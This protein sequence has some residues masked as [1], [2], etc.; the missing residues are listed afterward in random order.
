MRKLLLAFFIIH[1]WTIHIYAAPVDHSR[2]FHEKDN[3]WQLFRSHFKYHI[4]LIAIKKY[5]DNSVNIILSEPPNRVKQADIESIIQPFRASLEIK[6]WP[7]GVDGFVKDVVI[8][9]NALTPFQLNNLLAELHEIIF[10]TSYKAVFLNLDSL[11]AITPLHNLNYQ[12]TASELN[13]W[14]ITDN[15]PFVF[16]DNNNARLTI[17]QIIASRL[18]GEYFSY[19]KAFVLWVMPSGQNISSQ[20]KVIRQFSLDADL[21]IGA[22]YG[23]NTLVVIGRKRKESVYALPPLRTESVLMLAAANK[24]ELAQSYERNSLFAGKMTNLKDWAPIYLSK[25]LINTE[26]GSLLNITDQMLKS[27][28]QMNRIQYDNFPYPYPGGWPYNRTMFDEIGSSSLTY[29]WNTRGVGYAVKTG[30]LQIYAVNRTGSLPVSYFPDSSEVN[31][32]LARYEESAYKYFSGLND[33]NLVKVGQYT[34]LYQ[35]FKAFNIIAAENNITP[36]QEPKDVLTEPTVRLLKDIIRLDA[37]TISKRAMI[38]PDQCVELVKILRAYYFNYGETGL[39]EIAKQANDREALFRIDKIYFRLVKLLKEKEAL[40]IE[41]NSYKEPYNSIVRE[42]NV[43]G[44]NLH[45]TYYQEQQ[46]LKLWARLD[47]FDRIIMPMDIDLGRMDNEAEK[48]ANEADL[49][50]ALSTKILQ[51]INLIAT[52]TDQDERLTDSIEKV[53]AQSHAAVNNNTWIKTP[54]IVI[55]RD[56]LDFRMEGGH[57]IDAAIDNF[58]LDAATPKGRINLVTVNGKRMIKIN[59]ADLSRVNPSFQKDLRYANSRTATSTAQKDLQGSFANNP[60]PPPRNVDDVFGS[61]DPNDGYDPK[62]GIGWVYEEK[63]TKSKALLIG[64]TEDG[65]FTV[66]NKK[67]ATCFNIRE[68]LEDHLRNQPEA[69]VVVEF[70]NFE[71]EEAAYFTQNISSRFTS[72]QRRSWKIYKRK[73][74]AITAREYDFDKKTIE[75]LDNGHIRITIPKKDPSPNIFVDMVGVVKNRFQQAKSTIDQVFKVSKTK[76]EDDI[77][78]NLIKEFKT[79]GIPLSKIIVSIDDCSFCIIIQCCK[80]EANKGKS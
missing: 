21:I 26:Y 35:I 61:A 50:L 56:T 53:Y 54:S 20:Q 14:F 5:D 67:T 74:E 22:V 39:R 2:A 32:N 80:E 38:N 45:R 16:A 27:W 6:P 4:Q 30:N 42:H 79:A 41:R 63:R 12:V 37:V 62:Q 46:R 1:C 18:Q 69:E 72:A 52:L 71:P 23:N 43:L 44:H 31:P 68:A 65:Y 28:S 76:P 64:K 70:A 57:N 49:R 40:R 3:Q 15:E 55:S 59:P 24:T 7:I 51:Q 66:N 58:V 47:S 19:S 73:A 60:P 75:Q 48:L 33:P 77:I 8:S 9:A 17:R 78:T 34:F 29:N 13:K 36:V 10:L 25:E 11:P